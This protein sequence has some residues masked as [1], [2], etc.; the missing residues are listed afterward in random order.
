MRG[1]RALQWIWNWLGMD[2]TGENYEVIPAVQPVVIIDGVEWAP[3]FEFWSLGDTNLVAG[4]VD[5]AL[6]APP[7]NKQRLWITLWVKRSN[8]AAGDSGELV[9]NWGATNLG[10]H[11]QEW[12]QLIGANSWLPIIGGQF[13]F[14]LP[15]GSVTSIRGINT[16]LSTPDFPLH[17]RATAAAAVGT[18]NLAGMFVDIPRSAP[19]SGFFSR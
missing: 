13:E 18:F 16:Q 8:I 12:D 3:E 6:G 7:E 19:L 10:I 11:R 5:V 15:A 1:T 14:Q 2:S 9:R 17:Y 4:I